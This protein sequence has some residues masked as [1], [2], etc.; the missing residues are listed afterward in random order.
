VTQSRL[1]IELG[2]ST[3]LITAYET[4]EKPLPRRI[5]WALAGLFK[6]LR[7][8]LRLEDRRA[9]YN[10]ARE[11]R[12]DFARRRRSLV[13]LGAQERRA[14]GQFLR[15]ASRILKRPNDPTPA[16]AE[17]LERLMAECRETRRKLDAEIDA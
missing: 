8:Q 7:S 17:E 1:A 15:L 16:E 3:R 5:A 6:P 12:R 11:R 2:I 10:A 14:S 4:G 13:Q 9:R